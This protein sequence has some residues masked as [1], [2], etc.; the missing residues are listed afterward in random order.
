MLTTW[1]TTW[2]A[3]VQ[4]ATY[5]GAVMVGAYMVFAGEFTVGTII[6]IGILTGRTL[7]PLA[8]LSSTLAKWTNVKSALEGL[9]AIAN[10]R[11][12]EEEG[13]HYLRR[14]RLAGAYELRNLEFRYDA[15]SAPI[16]E[17]GAL[18]IPQ[19]Q[20]VAVLGAKV[21][22]VDIDPASYNLDPA[23]LDAAITP[24]TKA[25]IPVYL[26]GLP[27][28][29]PMLYALANKYKLRI[30]EDAAQALTAAG[31]D[32]NFIFELHRESPQMVLCDLA[33]G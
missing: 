22:Y 31:D 15:Q 20:H 23:L 26:A 9:D 13:R 17:I 16:V 24:R 11:Q 4:Q 21:V 28:D 30:V 27:L 8:G 6:A 33:G 12:H 5:I 1:L 29:M 3:G 14:S 25:I 19:G 32:D 2:A 18:A 7:G 10:A